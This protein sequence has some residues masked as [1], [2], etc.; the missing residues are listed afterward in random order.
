MYRP[1]IAN[2]YRIRARGTT[3]VSA[4][5]VVA[6]LLAHSN[7][8]MS[9]SP[10]FYDDDPVVR[11]VD[12]KDASDVREKRINL[13]YHQSKHLFATPGDKDDRR[14]LNVNTVD[15]VPNS[16]WFVDRILGRDRSRRPMCKP[17]S[18]RVMVRPNARRRGRVALTDGHRR[19]ST[20][21]TPRG[22]DGFNGDR[23]F[24]HR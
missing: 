18:P 2:N 20:G 14:A 15:E 6:A 5:A 22:R 24:R 16:S 19:R 17:A 11:E 3:L 9:S 4:A 8:L 1:H 13:I 21:S 12:T 7:G 23:G 10:R